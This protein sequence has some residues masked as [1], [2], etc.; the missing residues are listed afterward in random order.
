MGKLD[1]RV[2]VVTGGARG[3]GREYCLAMA[4]EGADIAIFDICQNLKTIPYPMSTMEQMNKTVKE[5]QNLGRKALGIKCDVRKAEDLEAAYTKTI[6]ELGK[7]DILVANAGVL[8]MAPT[9]ELKEEV[10]DETMDVMLKGVWL[11][12][13]YITPHMIKRRSGSMILVSSVCGIKGYENLVHYNVAKFGV[14]G[15][16][17][18]LAKE[19]APHNIR[20]NCIAPSTAWTDLVHNEAT[21]AAF[22]LKW[23]PKKEKELHEEY[24][25][26]W[27]TFHLLQIGSYEAHLAAPS[28]VFLASDDSSCLTGHTLPIDG[29]LLAR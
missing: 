10:W 12:T 19:L 14:R 6:K 28:V 4:K 1:G 15:V 24:N 27:N 21:F 29:G 20:V 23:D 11:T 2:A 5:I 22:N 26:I 7:V 18:T 3:L 16:M 13:K 25:K 8:S 17:M 9:W